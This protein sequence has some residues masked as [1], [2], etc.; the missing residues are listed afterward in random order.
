MF[1]SKIISLIILF[2][3]AQTAYTTQWIEIP[4]KE[5]A[6]NIH[7]FYDQASAQKNILLEK[8]DFSE[9]KECEEIYK[10][11]AYLTYKSKMNCIAH[12]FSPIEQTFYAK[13]GSHKNYPERFNSSVQPI[14]NSTPDRL[15]SE[16][17][18]TKKGNTSP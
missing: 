9:M 10:G 14:P 18:R 4:A 3:C 17:C 2:S 12:E 7:V 16:A 6:C 1:N 11:Q 13:D 15:L 5:N 8:Y